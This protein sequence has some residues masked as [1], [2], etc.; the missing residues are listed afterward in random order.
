V[1]DQVMAAVRAHFRPE[2]L[3]RVDEIILFHRLKREQMGRIVDIQIAHLQKL[4]EERKI[5]ITLDGKARDWLADKGYDPAY[6]ARPLKRAIQKSVQ[7]PLAE[8]I[9]SG[10]IKD[11]ETVKISAGRD[12]LIF[13]GARVAAAA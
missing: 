1:R 5:A 8:L 6:G 13:N 3:N 7:D 2:F 10:K 9:L 4:L 11:G 12:G